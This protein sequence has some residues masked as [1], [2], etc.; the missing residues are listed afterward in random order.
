MR[1]YGSPILGL[2]LIC[3]RSQLCRKYLTF[4]SGGASWIRAHTIGKNDSYWG[5]T[6]SSMEDVSCR[7]SYGPTV[8][9]L[10]HKIGLNLHSNK[11]CLWWWF[12]ASVRP[13][14]HENTFAE[15]KSAGFVS[16]NQQTGNYNN[17]NQPQQAQLKYLYFVLTHK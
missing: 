3:L 6:V 15:M 4:C 5:P 2:T 11:G 12:E 7:R 16:S 13:E 17:T 8:K 10:E 1:R 9:Y 14:L